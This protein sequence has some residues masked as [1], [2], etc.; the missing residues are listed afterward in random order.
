MKASKLL[1]ICLVS[2]AAVLFPAPD[3]GLWAVMIKPKMFRRKKE[4][5]DEDARERGRLAEYKRR[6][7]RKEMMRKGEE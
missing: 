6:Q 3:S 1:R 7:E 4:K 5:N 2:W